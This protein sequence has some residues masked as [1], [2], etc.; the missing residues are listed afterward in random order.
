LGAKTFAALPEAAATGVGL[1]SGGRHVSQG[2]PFPKLP[3]ILSHDLSEGNL[4]SF[5]SFLVAPFVGVGHIVA[6]RA[7]LLMACLVVGFGGRRITGYLHGPHPSDRQQ[8][9]HQCPTQAGC[10]SDELHAQSPI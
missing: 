2:I 4:Q 9:K 7:K 5:P 1:R 10:K 8:P 6:N 3:P